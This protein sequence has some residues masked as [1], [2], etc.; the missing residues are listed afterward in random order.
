MYDKEFR[1]WLGIGD[2]VKV[3]GLP[4]IADEIIQIKSAF[5]A[6]LEVTNDAETME[7]IRSI[8]FRHYNN[9]TGSTNTE[10]PSEDENSQPI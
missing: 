1:K 10:N 6:W 7:K 9:F 4:A 5:Y 3:I 8:A 2:D